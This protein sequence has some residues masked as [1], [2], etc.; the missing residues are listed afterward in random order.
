MSEH[1]QVGPYALGLLDPLEMSRFEEHLA[2]CDECATQLEWMLPVA[3]YLADVEPG[4][5]FGIDGPSAFSAPAGSVQPTVRKAEPPV[6][7][8]PPAPAEP[9]AAYPPLRDLH[10][11]RYPNELSPTAGAQPGEPA[12]VDPYTGEMP[13]VDPR[14]GGIPRVDPRTGSIPRV[15]PRTGGIPRIDPR[16]GSMPTVD[17]RTGGIPRIDPRTGS[18]PTVDPR[19]GSMP[20]V[21][22]RTG[23]MPTVD[24]RTGSMPTV[25]PRT[26]SMP[27]VDPRTGS[28][29]RVDPRTG[30]MPR[31]EGWAGDPSL[32]SQAGDNRI[33]PLVRGGDSRRRTQSRSVSHRPE[34]A[35]TPNRYRPALLIAAA[36]AILGAAAGAG[37]VTAGPWSTNTAPSSA[38][39]PGPNAEKLAATDQKTGVHA[40]VSLDSKAWGTL[41]SFSVSEV[42]GPRHCQLVAMLADGK[43]E[44]LSSWTVP[45]QGYGQGTKPPELKLTAATAL[46]RSDIAGLQV[47]DVGDDG[48]ASTLVTVRA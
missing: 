44:V 40:D 28:I 41:V 1:T 29:P 6:R 9:P 10:A 13:R 19:T 39:L 23:S 3:D 8:A 22:P 45:D 24:P 15:D 4:D 14:T 43:S 31:A 46:Q 17:P 7:A 20:T 12:G 18:M 35:G 27:R 33:V 42:D 34:P 5:L 32:G 26:G 2:E 38:A 47:Q 11:P 37:V 30:E 25:D 48:R 16:T 36:A 21:D